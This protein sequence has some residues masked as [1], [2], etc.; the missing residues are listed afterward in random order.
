MNVLVISLCFPNPDQPG[1]GAFVVEQVRSLSKL[2]KVHVISPFPQPLPLRRK[3]RLGRKRIEQF[4]KMGMIGNARF[5]RAYYIDCPRWG[6]YLNDYLLL[7][8]VLRLI[9]SQHL[10]VDV[11]HCHFA[12]PAGY[13]GSLLGRLLKKPVMITV[14]GADVN[15]NTRAVDPLLYYG[16]TGSSEGSGYSGYSKIVD[17]R[18]R[19][20]LKQ[21]NLVITVS[22]ELRE[23]VSALGIGTDKT[24]TIR[25]GVDVTRFVP[26]DQGKVRAKLGLPPTGKILLFVGGLVPIKSISTLIEALALLCRSDGALSLVIV[27]AGPEALILQEQA[28]RLLLSDKVLFVGTLPHD[29]I[30]DWM[31]ACDVFVLP[32]RYESFGCTLME[33]LA[34]GKPVVATSVGGPTEFLRDGE[35]GR[36][37]EPGNP[38]QIAAAIR[39]VLDRPWDANSLVAFARNNSWDSIAGQIFE[40]YKQLVDIYSA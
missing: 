1:R 7:F 20:A 40:Q 37:V 28:S 32:S 38:I 36:L 16:D 29:K 15:L 4:P 33:A 14:H 19:Y 12:Y 18:T 2:A 8:S 22:E 17:A 27:G 3:H 13:V 11:I 35:H 6:N 5:D 21:S 23:K 25:N 39:E 10:Q 24:I 30:P 34:C 9:R 31:N 26:S